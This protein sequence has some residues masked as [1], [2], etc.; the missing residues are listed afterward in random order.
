MTTTFWYDILVKGE[1]IDQMKSL[2]QIIYDQN[3]FPYLQFY[4][5]DKNFN[6]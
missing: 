2:R 3:Y 1:K 5:G 4:C 6:N